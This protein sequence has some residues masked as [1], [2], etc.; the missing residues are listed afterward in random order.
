[1][2]TSWCLQGDWGKTCAEKKIRPS[3]PIS[4]TRLACAVPGVHGLKVPVN[5][6]LV[7]PIVTRKLVTHRERY[8]LGAPRRRE[9]ERRGYNTAAGQ[10]LAAYKR[11]GRSV[12]IIITCRIDPPISRF[13]ASAAF[14]RWRRFSPSLAVKAFLPLRNKLQAEERGAA[15][16]LVKLAY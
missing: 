10:G 9:Y 8:W 11:T 3:S 12:Q 5:Q 2:L 1:M 4:K 7:T 16:A 13:V 14:W 15:P 6:A